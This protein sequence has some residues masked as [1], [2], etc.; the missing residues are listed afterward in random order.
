MAYQENK[1]QAADLLSQ[2]QSDIQQNFAELK[3]LIDINHGTF[4]AADEGKHKYV[5]FPEQAADPT[6]AADEVAVYSKLST[7]S[8]QSEL[9]LR[10]E[11]NGTVV[12]F[13][14]SGQAATGWTRFPS[15]I[16][17]KWG[18]GNVNANAAATVN[19]DT[20]E[21]FT[22]VYNVLVTRQGQ[23]GDAGALY[24]QS[25]TTTSITVYNASN[26]GPRVFYY[27]AIGI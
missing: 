23:A 4:A 18:T 14:S 8:A 10:N 21:P 11:N 12:E 22:T 19:F 15:G 24:Y 9:F 3:T 16:L 1:P 7:L 2:S 5:T 13:T 27:Q 20:T 17:L 25:F 26:S 6:T